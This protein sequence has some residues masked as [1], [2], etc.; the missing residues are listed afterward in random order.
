[1]R[2]VTVKK[3]QFAGFNDKRVYF[4]DGIV[5]LPFGH[6]L[7]EEVRK[8]KKRFEKSIHQVINEKKLELLKTE[9]SAV[10]QCERLRVLRSISAQPSI[11]YK[12]DSDKLQ[13][14]I[15]NITT[16]NYILNSHWL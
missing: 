10:W 11:H 12:S 4:Y 2:M 16:R 6:R 15:T 1:M 9:A 3:S 5:S 7:L 8:E 13:Q 14:I